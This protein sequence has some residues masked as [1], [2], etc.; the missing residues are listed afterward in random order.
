MTIATVV[1]CGAR[2][3]TVC[4]V[5]VSPA[6]ATGSCARRGWSDRRDVRSRGTSRAGR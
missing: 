1:A 4:G 3:V 5:A 6:V 2:V